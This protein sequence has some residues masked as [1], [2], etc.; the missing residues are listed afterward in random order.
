MS[1]ATRTSDGPLLRHPPPVSGEDGY[2]GP[3]G[4]VGTGVQSGVSEKSDP[5]PWKRCMRRWSGAS[6]GPWTG[7]S[8]ARCG[9]VRRLR[10]SPHE[11]RGTGSP[12]VGAVLSRTGVEDGRV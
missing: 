8:R 2:S 6:G 7:A 4:R 5:N 11:S 9:T 12:T 1:P 10:L 3:D